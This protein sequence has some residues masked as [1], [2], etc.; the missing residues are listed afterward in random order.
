MEY[1]KTLLTHPFPRTEMLPKYWAS[2]LIAQAVLLTIAGLPTALLLRIRW[3]AIAIILLDC[4]AITLVL[5]VYNTTVTVTFTD[6]A[7]DWGR[8]IITWDQVK[9]YEDKGASARITVTTRLGQTR[10]KIPYGN[11]KK[12]I[13]AILADYSQEK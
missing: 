2:V 9:H 11:N 10:I 5:W 12:R 8:S 13:L 4:C 7:M 6:R 3:A 1:T